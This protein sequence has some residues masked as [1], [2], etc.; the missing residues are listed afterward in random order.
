MQNA[1]WLS[2]QP[3]LLSPSPNAVG[4]VNAMPYYKRAG[5]LRGGPDVAS[6]TSILTPQ[7]QIYN[8]DNKRRRLGRSTHHQRTRGGDL[9]NPSEILA[10]MPLFSVEPNSAYHEL[11]PRFREGVITRGPEIL[12]KF[13]ENSSIITLQ[14]VA[15]AFFNEPAPAQGEFHPELGEILEGIRPLGTGVNSDPDRH[16]GILDRPSASAKEVHYSIGKITDI[17]AFWGHN[18][19]K[20]EIVGFKIV[21][22]LR[23]DLEAKGLDVFAS[24]SSDVPRKFAYDPE[25][26][27]YPF[28]F[29]PY[30]GWSTPTLLDLAYPNPD[31]P[32]DM[33]GGFLAMGIFDHG[34]EAQ[35]MKY[36]AA[37]GD[38]SEA[39]KIGTSVIHQV[40]LAFDI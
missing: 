31:G 24:F 36:H 20:G 19:N 29:V 23:S 12:N 27:D 15:A 38:A 35:S 37:V 14:Q 11:Q 34:K 21:R 33:F 39:I 8:G 6:P 10:G 2:T 9:D 7:G 1:T 22:G 13:G 17:K 30:H 4:Q 3:S 40:E 28:H 32:G 16:L 18:V 5:S 25:A 26:T